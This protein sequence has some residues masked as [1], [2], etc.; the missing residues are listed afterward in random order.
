MIRAAQKA[1]SLLRLLW[2]SDCL[3]QTRITY[4][5]LTALLNFELWR[6]R[7]Y[8]NSLIVECGILDHTR[9]SSDGVLVWFALHM[10]TLHVYISCCLSLLDRNV[11]LESVH[12][13]WVKVLTKQ[14]N[15]DLWN[16]EIQTIHYLVGEYE[17]TMK[18]ICTN[19]YTYDPIFR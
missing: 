12:S 3:I 19:L 9:T 14:N 7:S 5:V 10:H 13:R 17:Q 4:R 2:M 1:V 8:S 6:M 18:M 11:Y 15:I 16:L